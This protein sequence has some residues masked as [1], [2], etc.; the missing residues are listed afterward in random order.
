MSTSPSQAALTSSLSA[1]L[2][3]L[4]DLLHTKQ[5]VVIDG[6]SL[7]LSDAFAVAQLVI[8][9]TIIQP[10]KNQTNLAGTVPMLPSPKTTRP[11]SE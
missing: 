11:F 9:P 5:N 4:R 8:S 3:Q 1:S 7:S 10:V 2:R 6:H